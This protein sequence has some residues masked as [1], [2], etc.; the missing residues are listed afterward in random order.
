MYGFRWPLTTLVF[1]A[2]VVFCLTGTPI[3]AEGADQGYRI[4]P[5]DLLALRVFE[6][7]DLGGEFRVGGD[8]SISLP[9]I[10]DVKVE[11]LT[12]TEVERMLKDLLEAKYL[13]RGKATVAIEVRD[14]GFRPIN[15]IG[16]VR[17]PGPLGLAGAWTLLEALTAAGGL[18]GS[19]GNAIYIMR[20]ADNGLSDQVEIAV[21]DLLLRGDPR[22][23]VPLEPGDLVNVP[24]TVELT[25]SCLGEVEAPGAL[26][27]KSNERITLLAAIARAGGLTERASRK[28]V[29]KR[30]AASGQSEEIVVDYKAILDGKKPDLPLER[31]DLIFVKQSFF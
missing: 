14:Y 27:F 11:G 18:S 5:K 7:P 2:F 24:E 20:R 29:V 28:I 8:G 22:V 4:G 26:T 15:V 3:Q 31:G 10:G 17:S 13:Q 1:I 16:A 9:H 6:A 25:V 21:D 12:R 19:H 30:E 23:N